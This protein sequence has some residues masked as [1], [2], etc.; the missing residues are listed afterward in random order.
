VAEHAPQK[1]YKKNK[2]L[3]KLSHSQLHDFA[4]TRGLSRT[5]RSK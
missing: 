3:T 4:A 5:K 2:G 1:L